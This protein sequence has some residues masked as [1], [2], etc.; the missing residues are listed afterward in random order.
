MKVP[1]VITEINPKSL[2]Q[3]EASAS[4]LSSDSFGNEKHCGRLS[5]AISFFFQPV[6]AKGWRP[7]PSETLQE[8]KLS[9]VAIFTEGNV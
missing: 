1:T 2:Q 4:V 7:L 9:L 6:T 5:C 8:G 3:I